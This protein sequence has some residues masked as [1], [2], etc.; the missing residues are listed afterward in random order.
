MFNVVNETIAC[1]F[2]AD[3]T[4]T[5]VET[6][7][8]KHADKLILEFLIGSE[9]VTYL[10]CTSSDISSCKFEKWIRDWVRQ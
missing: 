4:A 7:S 1:S 8:G 6:L 3:K 5:P 10:A 9:E 2:W